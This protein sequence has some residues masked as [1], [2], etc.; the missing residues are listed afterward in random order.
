LD[1]KN[2]NTK[3]EEIEYSTEEVIENIK[4]SFHKADNILLEIEKLVK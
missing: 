3:V 1:I 4:T 2:P